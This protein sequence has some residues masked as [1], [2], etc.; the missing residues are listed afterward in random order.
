MIPYLY[1]NNI[2]F[3]SFISFVQFVRSVLSTAVQATVGVVQ[4]VQRESLKSS[5]F[6]SFSSS[7]IS[8]FVNLSFP[9][10]LLLYKIIEDYTNLK[11]TESR[12]HNH[13]HNTK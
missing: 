1:S 12:T 3:S 4:F 9:D 13:T 10:S 11:T 2:Q 7:S 6:S 5:A 8:S